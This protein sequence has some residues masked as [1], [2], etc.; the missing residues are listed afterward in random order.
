MAVEYNAKGSVIAAFIFWTIFGGFTVS[1]LISVNPLSLSV[2][3]D[4]AVDAL[5]ITM[6]F[7]INRVAA[8]PPSS[9]YSYGFHRSESLMNIV[10]IASFVAIALLSLYS[11]TVEF[12]RNQSVSPFST[13]VASVVALP[14]ILLASLLIRTGKESN[15]YVIFLHSV[16]DLLI[17]LLVLILSITSIF[18]GSAYLI[19]L[20][21]YAVI[22]LIV[23]GNRNVFKRSFTVLMEGSSVDVDKVEETIE[24]EFPNAH[25]LHI[26]DICE[27]QRVATLHL[28]F[29]STT[30][31]GEI[32][33]V[34]NMVESK[35]KN[36]GIT[37]V[38]VQIES[39]TSEEN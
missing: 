24:K 21:N 29:P 27:H 6:V 30:R 8:K 19:Y 32:D 12:A 4:R 39:K 23:F 33:S 3:A 37:H 34:R 18:L 38:T 16:Q 22:G 17:V 14:L 5:S 15:F 1:Y 10:V 25:H 36:F 28:S 11:S 26:W 2:M 20:G 13:L 31:I 35:L 9:H 7:L